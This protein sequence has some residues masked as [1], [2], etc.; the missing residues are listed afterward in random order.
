MFAKKECVAM[1]LAGGQG[2][3]LRALT[4]KMAKPAVSFGG[5]YRIIDFAL[6]NCVNSGID[7][8]GVLTQYSPFFL[9]EYIGTG[10]PWDLDRLYGGVHIL[11]PYESAKGAKF[12]N[13]TAN[14]IY[15]NMGFIERYEPEYVLIL[16]GDH[17]Y[18][19]NYDAMLKH[20]KQMSADCTIA[21]LEV[22]KQDA[23]RFGIMSCDEDGFVFEF[24]EKPKNPKTNLASMG[25]YIFNWKILKQLLMEDERNSKS[26]NDFGQDIIPRMLEKNF[27]LLTYNFNGYWKDVGT[28]ESLWKANMDLLDGDSLLNL[29]NSC[30]KIYTRNAAYPPHYV[31][32]GCEVKNS[33]ITEGC[34]IY[35][36]VSCS[37]LSPG[38]LVEKGASIK[39]SIIMADCV[40]KSGACVS[41]SVVGADCYIGKNTSIG[42][43]KINDLNERKI[44][45]I[46][47]KTKFSDNAA[48]II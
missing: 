5:K 36:D 1:L 15:Q 34:R 20:H 23:S 9:N 31:G 27:R 21:V 7:T 40:I 24:E 4:R 19:M 17:I 48:D 22:S 29:H 35:G 6:S 26:R 43:N 16:S 25:I 46:G 30:W 47:P 10:E 41:Y 32:Y 13:G 37:V 39:K 18:K 12:Y 33:I 2:S 8:V 11:P 3:R 44:T 28:I 14:A 42:I 45:V 38:V